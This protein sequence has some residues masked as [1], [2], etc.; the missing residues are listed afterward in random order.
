[1]HDPPPLGYKYS[2]KGPFE[3]RNTLNATSQAFIVGPRSSRLA[4]VATVADGYVSTGVLRYDNIPRS[5][6]PNGIASLTE[7]QVFYKIHSNTVTG[8]IRCRQRLQQTLV[9]SPVELCAA[10]HGAVLYPAM[11]MGAYALPVVPLGQE[12]IRPCPARVSYGR[13]IVAESDQLRSDLI[14]IRNVQALSVIRVPTSYFALSELY[15]RLAVFSC[16]YG[17]SNLLQ[18]L[19]ILAG[20]IKTSSDFLKLNDHCRRRFWTGIWLGSGS[21]DLPGN[22]GP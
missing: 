16:A 9:A 5:Q 10:A 17:V 1:M 13:D 20:G 8:A 3:P 21:L 7:R 2:G 22:I 19:I 15:L 18:V 6:Y 12:L 14:I 11:D 4:I